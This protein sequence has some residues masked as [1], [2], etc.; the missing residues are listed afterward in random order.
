M[1]KLNL[2]THTIGSYDGLLTIEQLKEVFSKGILDQLAITDRD[3]IRYAQKAQVEFGTERIIVG[4][5]VTIKGGKHLIGLFLTKFVPTGLPAE[6]TCQ[7]IRSQGGLVYVPHPLEPG[8]GIGSE[9]LERLCQQGLIDI[10][11]GFNAWNY[12]GIM[13][14]KARKS[15]NKKAQEIAAKY[16]VASASGSDSKYKGTLANA[17][18]QIEEPAT[19]ENLISQLKSSSTKQIQRYNRIG[20]STFAA[21]FKAIRAKGLRF[22]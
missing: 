4:Q 18:N 2:H 17:Y 10:V 13:N 20:F 5:E 7:L 19:K 14:F 6:R 22:R 16:N 11:E 12:M 15:Q 9:E 8:R 1:I 21:G 3:E